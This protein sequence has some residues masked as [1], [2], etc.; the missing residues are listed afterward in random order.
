MSI[1]YIEYD[2]YDEKWLIDPNVKGYA[3]HLGEVQVQE[4]STGTLYSIYLDAVDP[5]SAFT[6]GC[7]LIRDKMEGR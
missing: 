2:T 4:T 3:S 7:N 6:R 5:I 1:Y